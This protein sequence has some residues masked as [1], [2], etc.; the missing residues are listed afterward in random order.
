[1][2]RTDRLNGAARDLPTPLFLLA[3]I[4]GVV[5][6]LNAA[7]L[8]LHVEPGY[9]VAIGGL[10]VLIAADLALL[11]AIATPF[12]G[13]LRIEGRPLAR[14]HADLEVGR[15]GPRRRLGA[16]AVPG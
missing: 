15:Y 1:M 11:M 8:A 5:L 7:V 2:A 14:V 16:S 4:S 13:D 12:S 9:G 10:I 6:A 3:F